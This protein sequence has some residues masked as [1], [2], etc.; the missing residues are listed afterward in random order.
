MAATS[1]VESTDRAK[2][3]RSWPS[4]SSASKATTDG[5]AQILTA[6][7]LIFS[8]LRPLKAAAAIRPLRKLCGFVVQEF[9]FEVFEPFTHLLVFVP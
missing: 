1:T 8:M 2:T 7:I 4:V 6:S 5:R 3:T 9:R